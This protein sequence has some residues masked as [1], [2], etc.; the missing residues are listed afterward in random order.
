MNYLK[1]WTVGKADENSKPRMLGS[2]ALP[3][4]TSNTGRKRV[5]C[6]YSLVVQNPWRLGA[7]GRQTRRS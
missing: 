7:V 1:F 2:W 6:R 4:S 5:V 3:Q